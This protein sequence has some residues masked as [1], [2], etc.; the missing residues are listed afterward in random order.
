MLCVAALKELGEGN[1]SGGEG[2]AYNRTDEW[3]LGDFLQKSYRF[4]R[5]QGFAPFQSCW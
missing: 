3:N 1:F 2:K 4:V 5:E